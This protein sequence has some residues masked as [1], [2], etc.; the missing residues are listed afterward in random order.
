MSGARIEHWERH[1]A[2][3]VAAAQA[4]PFAWSLNDCPTFAFETRQL[5]TGGTDVAA[6]WRGRYR[7]ARG[8]LRVMRRLGWD[9]LEVMGLALLGPPLA[10]VHL[11]QRGDLVLATGGSGF[12]VCIG[13]RAVGM[14]PEG[15]VSLPISACALAWRV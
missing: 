3:A 15:L 8:G 11:A 2:E 5:L 9:T 14:A 6:L 1:L 4:R 10:S 13:A 7:T 12:G